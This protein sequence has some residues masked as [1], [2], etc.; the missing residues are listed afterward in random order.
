M[1]RLGYFCCCDEN[2]HVEPRFWVAFWGLW[3]NGLRG[4]GDW[5]M[6]WSPVC[7]E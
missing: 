3:L 2:V 4:L 5:S 1:L 6:A 7:L